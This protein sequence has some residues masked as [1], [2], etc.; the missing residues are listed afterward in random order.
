MNHR[1]SE[2][3]RD[4][5]FPKE[6]KDVTRIPALRISFQF[7]RIFAYIAYEGVDS[8]YINYTPHTVIVNFDLPDLDMVLR[9]PPYVF[10]V[11]AVDR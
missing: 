3:I 11:L 8:R 6:R 2:Y 9:A 5:C 1:L 4:E 7:V 10:K